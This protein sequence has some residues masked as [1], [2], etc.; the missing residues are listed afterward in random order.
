M[1]TRPLRAKSYILSL[2]N[3]RSDIHALLVRQAL[4]SLSYSQLELPIAYFILLSLTSFLFSLQI[5]LR[6]YFL[7]EALLAV[8]QKKK[9]LLLCPD[10]TLNISN[11]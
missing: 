11:I 10:S 7:Q 4:N 8:Y 5:S 6:E 9:R 2:G 1:Y 3:T